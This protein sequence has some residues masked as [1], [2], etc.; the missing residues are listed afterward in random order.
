MHGRIKVKTTVEQAEAKRKEREEK[1][2]VFKSGV[3]TIFAKR[4]NKEFDEEA[5][6][7]T[8]RFLEQNPDFN[9]LW[10]FR[11]DIL[12]HMKPEKSK[13]SLQSILTEEMILTQNC[14]KTNPK[15]YGAW[16][17]RLWAMEFTPEPD[18]NKELKLCGFF[19]SMD[20]R[21]FHCWDYRRLVGKKC[22]VN[23]QDELLFT[24]ELIEKNFSNYSAWH[25]RSTLLPLVHPGAVAG[26][27][28]EQILLK[29]YELVQNAAFTDP[30]DQSV[31]FYH[32]WLLGRGKIPL[33]ILN[34]CV[35]KPQGKIAV[36]LSEAAK[37]GHEC[38][39][40]LELN[41]LPQEVTWHAV[42]K[43][44]CVST[45]WVCEIPQDVL[46]ED[47]KCEISVTLMK[48]KESSSLTGYLNGCES[49]IWK[50]T[51]RSDTFR[52]ELS[53][54]TKDVLEQELESCQQLYE[55]EPENK[56][57]LFTSVL[58]MRA[59]N[60]QKFK[61]EISE[62]MKQL[63]I[64]DSTRKNYYQDL[65]SKFTIENEIE[66]LPIESQEIDLSRKS[67]TSLHHFDH[68]L[69]IKKIDLSC[70]NLTS[71][72]PLCNLLCVECIILD[73]NQLIHFEGVENL[74][75]LKRLSAS[76][77]YISRIAS[78]EALKSLQL[79]EIVLED[80]PITDDP[81]YVLTIQN[82]LCSTS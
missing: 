47:T 37:V 3:K 21:N 27:V 32:R 4:E 35:L 15:S 82:L 54:A 48:E 70:N 25:Y 74:M 2:K 6:K 56:W 17:H 78:L 31:W 23:P 49:F 29:E 10:N 57:T 46:L 58:L 59:L 64:V 67:L 43:R 52:S 65:G 12:M 1:L 71:I 45:I 42:D 19:L 76:K 73:H 40:N 11:R 51:S 62:Y 7:L 16:H 66:I 26:S 30:N 50:K 61:S 38:K 9:T 8:G 34:I 81:N 22:K 5:L 53:A 44:S 77:N 33:E 41:K 14:L 20:E 75:S 28:D 72:Y 60:D 13:E 80:N 68:L 18:W 55:F 24:N 39:L 36:L 63:M 79:E 69:M